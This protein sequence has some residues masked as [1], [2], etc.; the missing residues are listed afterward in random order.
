MN[1]Q[2]LKQILDKISHIEQRLSIIERNVKADDQDWRTVKDC[3]SRFDGKH[4]SGY[5]EAI[6]D[7]YSEKYPHPLT[8]PKER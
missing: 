1:E 7:A 2:V 8:T 6:V 3:K 4:G 5:Q